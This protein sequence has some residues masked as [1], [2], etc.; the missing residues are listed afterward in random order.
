M[1]KREDKKEL[2]KKIVEDIELLK[3]RIEDTESFS[4]PVAPDNSIGR[5]SRMDAINNKS[6]F[7]ASLRNNRNRMTLLKNA[8]NNIDESEYG[9]CRKC[10]RQIPLERLK[11]RPEILFCTTCL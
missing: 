1:L 3:K 6:I 10:R 8:L 9:I 4:E 7:D 5:L 11:I 2:K